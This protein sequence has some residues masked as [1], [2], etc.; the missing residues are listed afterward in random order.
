MSQDRARQ[1]ALILQ[2]IDDTEREFAETKTEFKDRMTRLQNQLHT[3]KADILSGQ[4]ELVPEQPT[5]D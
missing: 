5:G 3:A 2:A 4:L 1:I